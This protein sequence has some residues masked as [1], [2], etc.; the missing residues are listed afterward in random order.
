MNS[1]YSIL[2]LFKLHRA[3][4]VQY[5]GR[6]LGD[7][8]QAEDVVQEAYL[9]FDTAAKAQSFDEPLAYLYRI[10]RNLSLDFGRRVTRERRQTFARTGDDADELA[11]DLSPEV[12]AAGRQELRILADAMAD[13]PERM[14][15]ALQMPR[16]GGRTFQEIADHLG[17]S[18]G[19]A[20]SLVVQGIDY[21]RDRLYGKRRAGRDGPPT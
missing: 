17:I 20:H 18:V 3:D 15:I 6:I 10:V 5:A 16:I 8:S 21:C 14:R 11:N 2:S 1:D 13:L 9:R 19:L 12:E 4:L 7:A